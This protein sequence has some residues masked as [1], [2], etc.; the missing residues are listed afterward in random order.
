VGE[1]FH[2]IAH[3]Y[4]YFLQ[5][6]VYNNKNGGSHHEGLE[7]PNNDQSQHQPWQALY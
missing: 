3:D 4:F 6:G 5:F 7:G 1:D 2:H